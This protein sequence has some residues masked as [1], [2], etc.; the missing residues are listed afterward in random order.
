MPITPAM[1]ELLPRLRATPQVEAPVV[2]RRP[3][4]VVAVAGLVLLVLNFALAI[5]AEIN[6]AVRDPAGGDKLTKLKRLP[7][8]PKLI[9]FGSSRTLLGFK[10][11]ALADPALN[12]GLPASGLFTSAISF[13]RVLAV[14]LLLIGFCGWHL[15][16]HHP[17]K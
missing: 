10:P 11:D 8:P 7:T 17:P 13:Q 9:Q 3:A 1:L 16:R 4:A 6:P 14:F 15:L 5:V 2:R 12:F